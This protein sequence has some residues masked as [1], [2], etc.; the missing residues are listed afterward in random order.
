MDIFPKSIYRGRR[1]EM[2]DFEKSKGIE[3]LKSNH[4]RRISR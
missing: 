1:I 4:K 3:L 2:E